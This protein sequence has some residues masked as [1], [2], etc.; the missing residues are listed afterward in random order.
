MQRWIIPASVAAILISLAALAILLAAGS[1]APEA[2]EAPQQDDAQVEAPDTSN[3]PTPEQETQ[4][5]GA[6]QEGGLVQPEEQPEEGTTAE[7]EQPLGGGQAEQAPPQPGPSTATV[8]ILGNSA[9]Y[10]SLGVIG[11]PETVQGRENASYEVEIETGGTG[12]DT[13]MA[14]CQK[15]SP[16]S[17]SVRINYDGEVVAQD[18]TDARLGTV[19]VAWNPLEE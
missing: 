16:G 6:T 1:T 8:R 19:S 9:Y 11:E 15:I 3:Q 17:L 7:D 5:G 12:L 10:C 13:V 18:E 2:V 14:A 4:R